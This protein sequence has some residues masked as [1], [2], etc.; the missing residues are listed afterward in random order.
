VT[1]IPPPPPKGAGENEQ[2]LRRVYERISLGQASVPQAATE[3]HGEAARI[4]E[5]A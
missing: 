2:L 4:L 5:R 1:P 3:F